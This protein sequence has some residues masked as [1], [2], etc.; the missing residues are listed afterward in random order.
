MSLY[1][2]K[3]GQGQPLVMIHGWGMHSGM[4]MQ[5]RD[6]LSQHFELHLV[7]LPGMGNSGNLDVYN[8]NTVAEEIVQKI[9]ANSFVLGWS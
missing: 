5:A 9:P 6:L 1:I 7:D 4:W 2:E 3:I 8:L